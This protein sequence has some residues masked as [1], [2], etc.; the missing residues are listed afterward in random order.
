[1]NKICP[2]CNG[3]Y[4]VAYFK[5]YGKC[6]ECS[7]YIKDA[8]DSSENKESIA[9]SNAT[10]RNASAGKT[11]TSKKGTNVPADDSKP[12]TTKYKAVSVNP[13]GV[14]KP[15]KTQPKTSD[16][17]YK[18]IKKNT[19]EKLT[20]DSHT[21]SSTNDEFN[22]SL[23]S[24]VLSHP[25]D[26]SEN[27]NLPEEDVHTTH[28]DSEPTYDITQMDINSDYNEEETIAENVHQDSFEEESYQD[29]ANNEQLG[30]EPDEYDDF[31]NENDN[32]LFNSEVNEP[33][34]DEPV[35]SEEE[36][37]RK[38]I[39]ELLV[40]KKTVLPQIEK[41]EE[42]NVSA[43]NTSIDETISEDEEKNK[44]STASWLQK[45]IEKARIEQE[46]KTE[47]M[48]IEDSDFTS[49][50]DGYYDDVPLRSSIKAD[51]IPKGLILKV[52][53]TIVLM[54]CAIAFLIYYA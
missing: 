25:V 13:S 37:R 52:I 7:K 50:A 28:E 24:N 8:I 33:E 45:R 42:E 51:V 22:K 11:D 35:L 1:M 43:E 46:Q 15:K 14:R 6:S 5:K 44:F 31:D 20:S 12:V 29:V 19:A 23:E 16:S 9:K 21:E 47:H 39:T 38:E 32:D 17:K 27:F 40:N 34:N 10:I 2:Y 26:T 48:E 54:F 36:L 41:P 4:D 3:Q 30:K 49:N 53:G 18:P